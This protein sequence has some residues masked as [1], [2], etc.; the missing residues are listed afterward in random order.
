[1]YKINNPK[2]KA[3]MIRD[4]GWALALLQNGLIPLTVWYTKFVSAYLARQWAWCTFLRSTLLI[5]QNLKYNKNIAIIEGFAG[6][7]APTSTPMSASD[8]NNVGTLVWQSYAIRNQGRGTMP[9]SRP[10]WK[11]PNKLKITSDT[12]SRN[13]VKTEL[14]YTMRRNP[15]GSEQMWWHEHEQ[16]FD[17]S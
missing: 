16:L 3:S 1:M 17:R 7:R 12:Q 10:K 2:Y 8:P 13:R 4:R 9:R 5:L 14:A 11:R 6:T 15:K